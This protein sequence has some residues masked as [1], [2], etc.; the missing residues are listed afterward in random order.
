MQRTV[1]TFA[2]AEC[3]TGDDRYYNGVPSQGGYHAEVDGTANVL[4]KANER[5]GMNLIIGGRAPNDQDHNCDCTI[6]D[7]ISWQV[8]S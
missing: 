2:M 8:S 4:G 7:V 6:S 3:T 5:E 1:R